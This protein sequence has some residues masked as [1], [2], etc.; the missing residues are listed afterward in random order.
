MKAFLQPAADGLDESAE[1]IREVFGRAF[2]YKAAILSM[3][4]S[5]NA[6][7]HSP[8]FAI[9]STAKLGRVGSGKL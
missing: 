2:R 7:R 6:R 8:R 3:Q 9:K 1:K 5:F 4:K